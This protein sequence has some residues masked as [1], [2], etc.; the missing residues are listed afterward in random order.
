MESCFQ[1]VSNVALNETMSDLYN[2]CS[3]NAPIEWYV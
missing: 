1:G 3:T 2:E